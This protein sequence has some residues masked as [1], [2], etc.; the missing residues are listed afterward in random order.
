MHLHLQQ[1]NQTLFWRRLFSARN[2]F[3][4]EEAWFW[5]NYLNFIRK[6]FSVNEV[7]IVSHF[8]NTVFLWSLCGN[9]LSILYC[10]WEDC[11]LKGTC[12]EP[13]VVDFLQ[14]PV[15]I[16][17]S[18]AA[19]ITHLKHAWGKPHRTSVHLCYSATANTPQALLAF[20]DPAHTLQGTCPKCSCRCDAKQPLCSRM[21]PHSL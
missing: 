5:E 10:A 21:S 1:S 3:P 8:L 15:Y 12:P 11:V 13:F 4:E 19:F 6:Y 9:P 18:Q 7:Y 20:L 14:I 2:T 16:H 17:R